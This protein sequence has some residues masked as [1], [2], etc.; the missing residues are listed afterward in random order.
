MS[1]EWYILCFYYAR[2]KPAPYNLYSMFYM[3]NIS[4][5]GLKNPYTRPDFESALLYALF[6]IMLLRDSIIYINV[7]LVICQ[8]SGRPDNLARCKK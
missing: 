4:G 2:C 8:D 1:L 5:L 7:V 6:T 3:M